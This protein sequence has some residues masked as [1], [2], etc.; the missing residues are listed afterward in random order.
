MG[1]DLETPVL[2]RREIVCLSKTH[3]FEQFKDRMVPIDCVY[4]YISVSTKLCFT[5][6]WAHDSHACS[7]MLCICISAH[8]QIFS[9]FLHALHMH[10]SACSNSFLMIMIMIS[11]EGKTKQY[12]PSI[13]NGHSDPLSQRILQIHPSSG[14]DKG[15]PTFNS[16]WTLRPIV[17]AGKTQQYP[18]SKFS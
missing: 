15:I 3:Q 17:Q 11:L 16:Q 6:Q 13:P 5:V 2:H 12:P 7:S 10:I 18:L 1:Q 9:L 4:T 8:V 14:Q